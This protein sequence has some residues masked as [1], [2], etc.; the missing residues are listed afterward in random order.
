MLHNKVFNSEFVHKNNVKQQRQ[1]DEYLHIKTYTWRTNSLGAI[2]IL[3]MADC[4]RG[5]KYRS[6]ILFIAKPQELK[7]LHIFLYHH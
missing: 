5:I 4:Y 3:A 2:E 6:S 7:E 1:D